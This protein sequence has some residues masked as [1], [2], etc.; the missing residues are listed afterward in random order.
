MSA[1]MGQQS[2]E[3]FLAPEQPA[4]DQVQGHRSCVKYGCQSV[5]DFLINAFTS[6]RT[7]AFVIFVTVELLT[8][9]RSQ[10]GIQHRKEKS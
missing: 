8:L 3:E 6:D 2:L 4:P 5:V 9:S 10:S 1:K 7:R